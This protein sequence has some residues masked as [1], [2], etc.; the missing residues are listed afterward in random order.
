MTPKRLLFILC[1]WWPINSMGQTGKLFSVET[2]LSGSLV[3]DL[4]QDQSGFIWIAT[5]DGLNRF[6]GIK[7]TVYRHDKKD[8]TSLLN[9]QVHVLYA[10]KNARMYVG[11][12]EGLQYYDPA[13]DSFHIIPLILP[14]GQSISANVTTICQRKNGDLL[15]GTSGHGTFKIMQEKGRLIGRKQVKNAASE[16]ILKILE[17]NQQNLWV[18]TE[19]KGLY[20]FSGRSVN[21][22]FVSKK[23]QNNII[24]S[25]CQDSY[26]RLFVGNISSGL[27]RY[28][29]AAQTFVSIPYN[30]QTNLPVIDLLVNQNNQ[31]VVATS[32]KGVKYF[33]PVSD[34]ILDLEPSVTSFDFSRSKVT[35]ML[36]DKAGNIWIGIYQKGLLLL[37]GNTNRFGYIGYKSVSRRSI[38][39]SAVMALAQ[40]SRGTVWVGTDSDGLYALP[41]KGNASIHYLTDKEGGT[42][43]SNILAIHEDSQKNLWLGSYLNGL[44]RF[45]QRTG[46]STYITKLVDK[47]GDNVQ[48]VFSIQED[49]RQRLWIGTMGSGIFRLDLQ[50]GAV[51]NFDALPGHLYRPENNNLPNSWTNCLLVTNDHKLFIGTFDGLGCLDLDTENFVSTLGT[52]RLLAGTVVYSL[53]EDNK[54][55]LWLGT[56]QGL[57]KMNRSTKKITSFDVDN[58]LPSNLIWAIRSDKMGD[59]WLSTNRGL[60]RMDVETNTFTN[61]YAADGLQG[62]EFSRSASL[63]SSQGELYFGGVNGV[64]YFK[65]DEIRVANKRLTVQIVDLYIRDKPVKKG[66]LSGGFQVVDTTVTNAREFNLAHH[67]NS[68]TLE[69]STMDFV[70]AERVSYQYSINKNDWEELRPGANRLTFDNL[71]PGSYKFRLRATFNEAVSESQQVTVIIHPV[72]YLSAWAKLIYVMLAMLTGVFIARTVRNR[73]RAKAAFLAHQRQEEINEAKLQF[74]INIAHEIR[75]PLTLVVSPLQ[76]L[77]NNDQN[78]ERSH[79]YSIMGRNTK[80]ILDLVNQLMDIRKIEKGQMT[81]QLAT[82]ELTQ[83]TREICQL[84]EEQIH[85]RSIQFVMD[86]PAEQVFARIDPHNFDKVLINVLSNAFKFTPAGGMIRVALTIIKDEGADSQPRLAICI[87]DSGHCISETETERIFECFYQSEDHRGYNQQGTGIGLHL[88]KQLVELHGGTIKAENRDP[89]GCRFLISIPLELVVEEAVTPVVELPDNQSVLFES[90]EH[91]GASISPRKKA[92]RIIIADDDSEICNYLSEELASEYTVFAYANG[93]E[94]YKGILK[95]KPDLVVSD[96][97]MPVMDGMT[98]CRKLRANP[99]I[100]HIPIILLTAKTEESSNA[101]GLELGADAYITKPFNIDILSKTIKSL[102][103]N[104][105]I[106]RNNENE[107]QYQEEFIS[108][109]TIKSADTKLLEK[110]HLL[111]NKNIANP[112]LSVEMIANEIGISRVHLHRKLKELTN[113]TTRDLIR[114]IRLKQAAE[115]LAT[116]GLTVSEVAFATGFANVNNFSVSFKELYGVSPVNYA[117]QHLLKQ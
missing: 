63:I 111:I 99:L 36:E 49:A 39:S 61:F 116:K 52:N 73:R 9:N 91:D 74:F 79:L 59:I 106:I 50:S 1:L 17:D 48:R 60:S 86:F 98:L 7:F 26:G 8:S 2:G 87:E 112:E 67:D 29:P 11:S 44:S 57:K 78:E 104:R 38:G 62:N 69:F 12:I 95:E 101:L 113:S 90:A 20:R 71:S 84:F 51:K 94:A 22:Y 65:P 117:E 72:W 97:M 70:D 32:G 100:N 108:K 110:V 115:L 55:N 89:I 85:T 102:I 45:D 75:T 6:D 64:T 96:V 107:Q 18:S 42:A 30:G 14:N 5:E 24:G 27:Y 46:K 34:K 21:A 88:V 4:W 37:A 56:S 47:R 80:R 40:D 53:F 105:Q 92:R 82:V 93:E 41:P 81:L 28:D 16:L 19:D 103:R 83:F 68:F 43:P 10:D 33:D 23:S 13:T 31:I 76:K 54:G 3:T 77:I 114:T 66:T 109:I 25:I 15:V 58:G 35:T